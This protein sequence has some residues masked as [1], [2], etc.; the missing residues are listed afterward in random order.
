MDIHGERHSRLR[1]LK[2]KGSLKK[3]ESLPNDANVNAAATKCK[4][5]SKGFHSE[6][7]Q[8]NDEPLQ[9]LPIEGEAIGIVTLED[10]IEELLQVRGI[11]FRPYYI[12]SL[13]TLED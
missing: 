1:S 5:W 4:R 3:V 12:Y 13:V 7:L 10:V 9:N 2:S 11:F 8:I 6:V